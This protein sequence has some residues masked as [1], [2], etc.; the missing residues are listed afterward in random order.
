MPN[1]ENA[2]N[3]Y[4]VLK[5]TNKTLKDAAIASAGAQTI[6]LFISFGTIHIDEHAGNVLVYP[7]RNGQTQTAIID[8]GRGSDLNISRDDE[9]LK[10]STKNRILKQKEIF[11]AEFN[12]LV[13]PPLRSHKKSRNLSVEEFV[14]NVVSFYLDECKKVNI[15]KYNYAFGQIEWLSTYIQQNP[16]ICQVIFE[17]LKTMMLGNG[18]LSREGLE[19]KTIKKYE[20]EE[21]FPNFSKDINQFRYEFV[22]HCDA[23]SPMCVISGGMNKIKRRCKSKNL[24]HRH[25]KRRTMKINSVKF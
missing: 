2:T 15:D 20:H 19:M 14:V 11:F 8:F 6:R 25:E 17:S 16:Y 24:R 4:T 21:H 18:E 9:F 12:E 10:A 23:D 1:L 13:S 3:I 22:D 5:S 7:D